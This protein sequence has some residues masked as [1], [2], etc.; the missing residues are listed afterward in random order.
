[1][2]MR[3][4]LLVI[5]LSLTGCAGPLGPPL[6]PGPEGDV[7]FGILIL[8]LLAGILYH[9]QRGRRKAKPADA[10]ALDIAR[11]RYARGE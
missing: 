2:S 7:V 6:G 8:L 3:L 1:M 4:W 10:R 9:A 11:E 5:S